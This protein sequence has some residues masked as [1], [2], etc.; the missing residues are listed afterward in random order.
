MLTWTVA[1]MPAPKS[2]VGTSASI[3]ASMLPA[4]PDGPTTSSPVVAVTDTGDPRP[5]VKPVVVTRRSSPAASKTKFPVSV[6]PA[7]VRAKA[8]PVVSVT[9]SFVA[10]PSSGV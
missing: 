10:F 4:T 2:S 7:M 3:V 5:A 6:W 8:E 1:S 9:S